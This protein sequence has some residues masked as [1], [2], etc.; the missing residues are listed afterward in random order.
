MKRKLRIWL[1]LVLY[2]LLLPIIQVAIRKCLTECFKKHWFVEMAETPQQKAERLTR[3][4]MVE[5]AGLTPGYLESQPQTT[6]IL[7]D[8]KIKY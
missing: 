3:C 6:V 4:L 8:R 2:R 1:A 7:S 5:I